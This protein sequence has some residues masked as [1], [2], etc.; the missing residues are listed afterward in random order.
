MTEKK[1]AQK[2]IHCGTNSAG[3]PKLLRIIREKKVANWFGS[4]HLFVLLTS[5]TSFIGDLSGDLGVVDVVDIFI[6]F[7]VVEKKINSARTKHD[8][9][10]RKRHR[11]TI[12]HGLEILHDST[13]FQLVVQHEFHFQKRE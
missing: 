2:E 7:F 4:E 6:V 13:L 1:N 3:E 12:I 10:Q 11:D 8:S 9:H 5:S